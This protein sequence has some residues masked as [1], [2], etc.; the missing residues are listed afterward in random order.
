MVLF[1]CRS[2]IVNQLDGNIGQRIKLLLHS[3]FNNPYANPA[4][5]VPLQCGGTRKRLFLQLQMFLQDGGAMKYTFSVRG[6]GASGFC[7]MCKNLFVLKAAVCSEEDDEDC[8]MMRKTIKHSE[9]DLCT[10][11]EL[12]QAWDR[13]ADRRGN[14]SAGDWKLWQQATGM[15]FTAHGLLEDK[16]LRHMVKPLKQWCHDYM[17]GMC[18]NGVMNSLIFLVFQSISQNG[19]NVWNIMFS[20][21]QLWT[22]PQATRHSKV[23]Q[24]FTNKRVESHKKARKLK[25]QASDILSLYKMIA[26]Y[27]QTVC[28]KAGLCI[29]QCHAYLCMCTVL[30]LLQSVPHGVVTAKMITASVEAA[31]ETMRAAGWQSE[32]VPKHHWMLHYGDALRKLQMLPACWSMERKHKLLRRFADPIQNT[33][34]Y[35]LSMYHEVLTQELTE[36]QQEGVFANGVGLL[37]PHPAPKK[38]ALFLQQIFDYLL[39]VEACNTSHRCRL[40]CGSTCSKGDM[41]LFND[42]GSKHH[43]DLAFSCGQCWC[44]FEVEGI[45]YTLASEFGWGPRES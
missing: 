32:M 7:P 31:L 34:K 29:K 6:D 12:F 38:L 42:P 25:A 19:L 44:H 33:S 36:W 15:T 17:H 16:S 30:D 35:E 3:M 26:F 5:G 9:L 24:L 18:S 22:F 11:S 10:D 43:K 27:L 41:M 4:Y 40:G 28:M 13:L 23:H 21:L 2:E 14:V 37:A 20:W 45:V 1:V 8:S 39:G